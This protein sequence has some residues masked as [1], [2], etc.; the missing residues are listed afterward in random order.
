MAIKGLG[1]Q[2]GE[3]TAINLDKGTMSIQSRLDGS[4]IPDVPID[5]PLHAQYVPV[6]GQQVVLVRSD[7]FTTVLAWLGTKKFDA[8]IKSGEVMME[9]SGG[10]FVYLNQGGDV[11]IA[12]S[13]M[14]NVIKLLSTVGFQFV[15]DALSLV[16][17]GIGQIN[18]MED[19]IEI[20][21][22]IG[23]SDIETSKVTMTDT[24][25]TVEAL[26]VELGEVPIGNGVFSLSGIV[27][28]YSFDWMGQPI[29]GS[30][31][32]KMGFK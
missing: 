1:L 10:G 15:G 6:I 2:F 18:I 11:L 3:I 21:K 14:S 20:I 27:G 25:V 19:K 31:A 16:V 26:T 22:T 29:P 4:V 28:P 13:A 9:G 23:P 5:T 30:G 7:Y 12:D 32:V 17:K 24:K 8:P